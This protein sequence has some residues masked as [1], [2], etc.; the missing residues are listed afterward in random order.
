MGFENWVFVVVLVTYLISLGLVSVIFQ[1]IFAKNQRKGYI[2]LILIAI[3][4][5]FQLIQGYSMSPF[6][7]LGMFLLLLTT[8]A[9]TY[10]SIKKQRS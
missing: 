6:V 10:F 5:I 1:S 3:L 2:A 8:I 4:N 9:V 7:A